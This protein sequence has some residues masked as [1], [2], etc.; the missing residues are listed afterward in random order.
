[1]LD[2]V[3]GAAVLW[4][5]KTG[6]RCSPRLCVGLWSCC[7]PFG[8]A[9][10]PSFDRCGV[11]WSGIFVVHFAWKKRFRC[12]LLVCAAAREDGAQETSEGD[13]RQ[14][15]ADGPL[16]SEPP[17]SH[18]PLFPGAR[19]RVERVASRMPGALIAAQTQFPRLRGPRR[20]ARLGKLE[21]CSLQYAPLRDGRAF[22]ASPLSSEMLAGCP[23]ELC[24]ARGQR[25][26]FAGQ[27]GWATNCFTVDW[28][29]WLICSL[30]LRMLACR[31]HP[32]AL[33]Q[34]SQNQPEIWD[35]SPTVL[36]PASTSE[37]IRMTKVVPLCRRRWSSGRWTTGAGVAGGA[38]A[39]EGD[40][41]E[42]EVWLAPGEPV[43]VYKALVPC[44]AY[45]SNC[46]FVLLCVCVCC[47]LNPVCSI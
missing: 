37:R 44:K 33:L 45:N 19:S 18:A 39:E 17:H 16:R 32:S 15:T 4:N 47:F 29:I 34:H 23:R 11:R 36:K 43:C 46:V 9:T 3:G 41:D 1:M 8:I 35:G 38:G 22:T 13:P 24:A 2:V 6:R 26:C 12:P 10:E 31:S 7:A 20:V 27:H 30:R 5:R 40:G 14:A 25:G 28:W 42:E 21:L